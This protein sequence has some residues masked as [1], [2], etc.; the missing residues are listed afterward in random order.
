M[1]S[2]AQKISDKLLGFFLYCESLAV[3][4]SCVNTLL[5]G[6]APTSLGSELIGVAFWYPQSHQMSPSHS[7]P[8][9]L[10]RYPEHAGSWL[11][12]VSA[13]KKP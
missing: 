8:K 12:S 3:S 13:E 10:S 9:R 4:D 6:Y 1:R 7:A 2:G 11:Y 5:R